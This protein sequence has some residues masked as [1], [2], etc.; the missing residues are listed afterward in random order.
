[1]GRKVTTGVSKRQAVYSAVS[2][3]LRAMGW[4][5]HNR[6][7]DFTWWTHPSRGLVRLATVD[8]LE[9]QLREDDSEEHERRWRAPRL[10]QT[11]PE[12]SLATDDPTNDGEE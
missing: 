1:M 8:A 12:V 11:A 3:Y 2:D 4:R 10:S 6:S 7:D 5:R 9:L